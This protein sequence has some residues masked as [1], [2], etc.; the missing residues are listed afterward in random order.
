MWGCCVNSWRER[1]SG[2]V[3]PDLD[4]APKF[5]VSQFWTDVP[6]FGSS[7]IWDEYPTLGMTA[8]RDN[9]SAIL[10]SLSGY[11]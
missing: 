9:Q 5:G 1:S 10:F 11:V 3:I 4:T 7:Q 8:G 6:K 2:G